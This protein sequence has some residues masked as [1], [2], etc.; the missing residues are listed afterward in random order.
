LLAWF[1]LVHLPWLFS[2]FFLTARGSG[3]AVEQQQHKP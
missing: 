3:G 1:G 2:L